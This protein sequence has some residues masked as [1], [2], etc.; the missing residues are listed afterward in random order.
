MFKG[1]IR[2]LNRGDVEAVKEILSLYW[3]GEL[4]EHFIKRMLDF[5][6]KTPE[7]IGQKYKYF[8]AVDGGEVVGVTVSRNA[9]PHMRQYTHS[10]NPVEFYIMASKYKNKGIG[11]ALREKRL[12]EAKNDGYTEAVLYSADSHKDSWDFHDHSDFNRVAQAKA[13]NGETGYVW[14]LDLV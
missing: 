4:K 2:E 9:P 8:V 1:T 7:S 5:L 6:D 13:P 11:T 12:I 10:D 14:S 3:S